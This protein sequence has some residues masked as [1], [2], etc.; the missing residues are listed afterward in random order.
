MA[1][2]FAGSSSL[3]GCFDT[4]ERCQWLTSPRMVDTQ[5]HYS[6]TLTIGHF[7]IQELVSSSYIGK[8]TSTLCPLYNTIVKGTA[9]NRVGYPSKSKEVRTALLANSGSFIFW[10]D[11]HSIMGAFSAFPA[12][13]VRA[14]ELSGTMLWCFRPDAKK[15]YEVCPF[16]ARVC[17]LARGKE[18]S[19][20]WVLD[21]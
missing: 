4:T 19:D 10:Q 11:H 15:S 21:L 20:L 16:S 1:F 18:Y 14:V 3:R 13:A 5:V 12:R 7:E 8:L 9:M 6:D 2:S 17:G